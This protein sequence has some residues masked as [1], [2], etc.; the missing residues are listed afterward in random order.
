MLGRAPRQGEPNPPGRTEGKNG[1]GGRAVEDAQGGCGGRSEGSEVWLS[2][3]RQKRADAG[4]LYIVSAYLQSTCKYLEA[5]TCRRAL[6][7]AARAII[8]HQSIHSSRGSKSQD[9]LLDSGPRS[10]RGPFATS[11]AS[12]REPGARDADA[13][14]GTAGPSSNHRR[15]HVENPR[16]AQPCH[17][18]LLPCGGRQGAA[19]QPEDRKHDDASMSVDSPRA[20]LGTCPT[21]HSP[22]LC[23]AR[24][25]SSVRS[26]ADN[27]FWAVHPAEEASAA[28][29]PIKGGLR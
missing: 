14:S 11:A 8:I 3:S 16:Y 20:G 21:L 1:L 28:Y 15:C 13:A 26:A 5:Q 27:S 22:L 6:W 25:T 9:E 12:S 18:L 4:L 29:I 7:P 2:V 24:P 17:T 19:T 23:F 10:P